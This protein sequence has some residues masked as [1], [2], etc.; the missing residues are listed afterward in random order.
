MEP[1]GGRSGR[2]NREDAQN[3]KWPNNAFISSVKYLADDF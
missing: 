3:M 2:D 1:G